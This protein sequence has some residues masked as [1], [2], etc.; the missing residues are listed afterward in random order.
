[1]LYIYTGGGKGKTTAALGTLIRAHGAG[2][3]CAIVFFDKNSD[4]CNEF[5]TLKQLGIEAHIFGQN[6]IFSSPFQGEIRGGFRLSNNE[7][8]LQQ[9]QNA[10]NKAKELV[11]KSDVLILDELLNS[12]R[13]NQIT[14]Q[15]ALNFIDNFP[16]E[17]FLVLTGR[18]L[19]KEIAERANLISEIKNIKHP[20]DR[21]KSVAV[22]GIEY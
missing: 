20:F 7:D 17:K 8:D 22:P 5:K 4:Y 9:A 14:L 3:T 15:D 10:L 1:M 16:K 21:L 12:I 13:L 11:D 18:G 19:P 6:R 2:K